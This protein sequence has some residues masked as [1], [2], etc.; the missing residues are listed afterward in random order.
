M[1]SLHCLVFHVFAIGYTSKL[2]S[3]V[4]HLVLERLLVVPGADSLFAYSN[5]LLVFVALSPILHACNVL[6]LHPYACN[7]YGMHTVMFCM[8]H[9]GL[10]KR[11]M[12][13][14]L[15]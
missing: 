8:L 4:S 10:K 5:N 7:H 13:P 11:E 1:T 14:W 12:Q 3:Q 2:A 6:H 15:R 9:A